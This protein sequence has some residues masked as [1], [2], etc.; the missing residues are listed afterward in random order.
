[1]FSLLNMTFHTTPPISSSSLE[2]L[3]TASSWLLQPLSPVLDDLASR[4]SKLL[5][6]I[7]QPISLQDLDTSHSGLSSCPPQ[8]IGTS[9]TYHQQNSAPLTVSNTHPMQIRSTNSIVKPNPKYGISTVLSIDTTP[10]I[11]AQA[12]KHPEWFNAMKEEYKALLCNQTWILV[13]PNP[14]HNLVG[15]KWVF[16]IKHHPDGSIERFKARLVAIGFHQCPGVDFYET[17][18]PFINP[19]TVHT[20][21]SIAL[22][23]YWAIR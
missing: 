19:I 12:I 11:V 9:P 18:S 13:P 23:H 16:R 4:S 15:N 3:I 8:D 6:S 20:I 10:T 1:M 21:L 2:P 14:Q 17:F 22:H 5:P 7:Q